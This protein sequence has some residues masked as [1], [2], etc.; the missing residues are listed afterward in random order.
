MNLVIIPYHDWRKINKEGA[1]TRDAHFIHHLQKNKKVNKVIIINRPT[2]R[3][4]IFLKKNPP[5]EGKIVLQSGG[6]SL[7]QIDPKTYVL[8]CISWDIISQIT[9]KKKWFF[10]A[11]G[12]DSLLEFFQKSCQFLELENYS[13]LCQNVFASAFVRKANPIHAI[14]DAW[15]N[16]LQFPDNKNIEQEL[17][18]AYTELRDHSTLWVTN[19][20][21]NIEFFSSKFGVKKMELIKNGVDFELFQTSYAI[22]DDMITIP[23]PIIGFGGKLSHLLDYELY[24]KCLEAHPDKS[25]VIVG[26]K[27]NE[28]VFNKINKTNNFF[29]LG[30]KHYSQYPS[31][32]TH[33]DVG[34][35]PYVNN[36][37]DSGADS[38]KAYEYL[39]AG[40]SSLGTKGAGMSDLS[41]HMLVADNDQDFIQ[42]I[43]KALDQ[44][45]VIKLPESHS[46]KFKTHYL[47]HLF[48]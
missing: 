1:R 26:Q 22:P 2:T 39:A 10:E 35:I 19:S 24:N 23:R 27:L 12:W 17:K 45:N 34:I 21:K 44:K 36:H 8:D 16:F 20:K 18:V 11:F 14:F 30:D 28:E 9:K 48:A 42:K 5:I 46:W 33:F 41:E 38:I 40:L 3:L 32:V 15:D 4:E 6:F 31:Y 43:N 47:V 13:I 37:L 29:Y 25:F 7:Y